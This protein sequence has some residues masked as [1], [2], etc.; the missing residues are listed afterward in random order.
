MEILE[1]P[2]NNLV[3]GL[4]NTILQESRKKFN[5]MEFEKISQS[6]D[7]AISAH[8]GQYR[9]SG[10]LYVT[11]PFEAALIA[12]EL[13]ADFEVVSAA[14]LHDVLED[15]P[16]TVKELQDLFGD[17]IVDLVEG[18]T[19]VSELKNK[20]N[21]LSNTRLSGS[22]FRKMVVALA[23]DKRVL[24]VKIVDRLHNL[25]T[26]QFLDKDK[27]ALV[28]KETLEV[29]VPLAQ[30]LGLGSILEEMEDLAFKAYKPEDYADVV[31]ILS[32][33]RKNPENLNHVV[34]LIKE[35]LKT[36]LYESHFEVD[37]RHKSAWSAW[38]KSK[39]LG[40]PI[41]SLKD[42]LGVRIICSSITE[43]YIVLGDIHSKWKPVPHSFDDYIASPKYNNYRSLHT[44]IV[45][46]NYGVVEVQ[47]RSKEMHEHAQAGGASH[48]HYKH[49]SEPSWLNELISADS[50]ESD[51]IENVTE[52]LKT[53][54]IYVLTPKGDLIDLPY[55]SNV[56]DFAYAVHSEIGDRCVGGL[57][58]G[59]ESGK[60][61]ILNSGDIVTII[62]GNR[63]EKH[64]RFYSIYCKT[65]KARSA[66]RK[67]NRSILK[68]G[69]AKEIRYKVKLTC[70]DYPGVLL[71][72]I[73]C[74]FNTKSD[75]IASK[76]YTENFVAFQ[77]F[78]I[79]SNQKN[80]LQELNSLKSVKRVEALE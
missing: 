46:P 29:Y 11:H 15:T 42:L 39:R 25:R 65:S 10:E 56:L 37:G 9:K 26:I 69:N 16:V 51:Y 14:I 78:E 53:K 48:Y 17:T 34:G 21:Q 67:S 13:D 22:Q 18:V 12:L 62:Q 36:D 33:H 27:A 77:E 32:E 55:G 45:I 23:A 52:D 24:T 63:K 30:R 66:V 43:C 58:D 71:E 47:I 6:V 3:E 70:D 2:N 8:E 20:K 19:K 49:G 31:T 73:K 79:L 1:K 5:D 76:T 60:G 72:S 64:A 74:I 75:I 57:I 41:S 50:R 68:T 38:N 7:L 54:R 35:S 44:Q 61:S 28:G 4:K 40:V 59:V 80:L